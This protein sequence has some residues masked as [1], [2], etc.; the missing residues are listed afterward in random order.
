[1]KKLLLV[2]VLTIIIFGIVIDIQSVD[3]FNWTYD[4]DIWNLRVFAPDVTSPGKTE[5]FTIFCMLHEARNETLHVRFYLNTTTQLNKV[6]YEA[7]ILTLAEYPTNFYF[8]WLQN[9]TIPINAVNNGYLKVQIETVD[10]YF[11]SMVVTLIQEPTYSSL[12]NQINVLNQQ[13]VNYT[14]QINNLNIMISSLEASKLTLQNHVTNL[15]IQVTTLLNDKT[16]LQSQIDALNQNIT[17]L[18]SNIDS[19][20]S[21]KEDL[22]NQVDVLVENITE[23]TQEVNT[24]T[25]E[26]TDLES[27]IEGLNNESAMYRNYAFGLG[28]LALV[29]IGVAIYFMRKNQTI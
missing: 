2:T 3:A 5:N 24:L 18:Q 26:K 16:L 6:I 15:T 28:A 8:T 22:E 27:Q 4:E 14:V 13:I 21:E 10:K 11:Y 23:L 19:L 9:I 17:N 7:D 1:M 12:Q 20:N 25:E 29:A